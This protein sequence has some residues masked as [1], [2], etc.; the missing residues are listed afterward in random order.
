MM[1]REWRSA[2]VRMAMTQGMKGGCRGEEYI[3]KSR[4]ELVRQK[5]IHLIFEK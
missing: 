4:D 5:E 1:W 2:V 3:G